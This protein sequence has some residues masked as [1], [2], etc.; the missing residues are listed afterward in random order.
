MQ[1]SNF[2]TLRLQSAHQRCNAAEAPV[3]ALFDGIYPV[4]I[5]QMNKCQR[6]IIGL[7]VIYARS[8]TKTNEKR[9]ANRPEHEIAC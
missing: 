7:Q 1:N 3:P 9:N 5:V 6:L 2:T 8:Q 4:G